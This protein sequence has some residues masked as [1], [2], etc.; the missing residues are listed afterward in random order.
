[1]PILQG[2]LYCSALVFFSGESEGVGGHTD[3]AIGPGKQG[4]LV[5]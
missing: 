5:C 2:V 1:M 3:A 4:V